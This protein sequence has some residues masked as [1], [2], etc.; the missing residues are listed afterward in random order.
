MFFAIFKRQRT[1]VR[2]GN[3]PA[4]HEPDAGAAGLRREK[5]DEKIRGIRD[6]R[7]IVLHPNIDVI[8]FV[9]P[10]DANTAAGFERSVHSIAEKIDEELI[11]LVGIS[12]N[13]NLGAGLQLHLQ[14]RLKASYAP[15]PR[16][17]IDALK[18][19]RRQFCEARVG[20]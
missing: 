12:L 5:R 11:E 10:S 14:T 18:R 16:T 17:H 7:A 4:E 15:N 6:A 8:I 2:F 13:S 19:R 3:L 9:I 1:T 20:A